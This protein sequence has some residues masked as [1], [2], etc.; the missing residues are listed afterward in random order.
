MVVS[1]W[2]QDIDGM[3][4]NL[5]NSFG[6][7]PTTVCLYDVTGQLMAYE[8]VYYPFGNMG[9]LYTKPEHRRRG[10]GKLVVDL[11]A[12]KLLEEGRRVYAYIED[13][14]P[15]SVTLHEQVG[16]KKGGAFVMYFCGNNRVDD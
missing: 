15:A 9:M 12:R 3:E 7:S 11:L 2:K 6:H 16:F 5:R 14:N 13:D 4:K 8:L 1:E 10:L